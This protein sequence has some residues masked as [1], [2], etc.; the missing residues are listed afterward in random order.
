MLSEYKLNESQLLEAINRKWVRRS[1]GAV[2]AISDVGSWRRGGSETYVAEGVL[3]LSENTSEHV[4]A[5]AFVGWGLSPEQQQVRSEQR[6]KMIG[7]RGVPVPHL[8]ATYPAVSVEQ[9]I[10]DE[11]PSPDL[12]QADAAL[13]MGKIARELAHLKLRPTE[14]WADIRLNESIG[15]LVDFG[16][17]IV[18]SDDTTEWVFLL[19]SKL[20]RDSADA[21]NRGFGVGFF[22][23]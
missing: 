9:F 10:P 6:R 4:I 3:A 15:Y 17:D 18:S 20:S 1:A 14:L 21:F 7:A 12:M 8:Y 11:M 2:I 23:N 16:S 13:Q 5:K 19:Q 22:I